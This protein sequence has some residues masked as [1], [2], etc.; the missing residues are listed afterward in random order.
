MRHKMPTM[1]KNMQR[2]LR[3]R[4]Q[5]HLFHFWW[6]ILNF[7]NTYMVQSRTFCNVGQN[8]I[9][10]TFAKDDLALKYALLF[11]LLYWH[12][13][14]WGLLACVWTSCL[15]W[16]LLF[17][18]EAIFNHKISLVTPPYQR[19]WQMHSGKNQFLL[20]LVLTSDHLNVS[21]IQVWYNA[22][23]GHTSWGP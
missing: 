19:A 16:R 9:W 4:F 15:L 17:K 18:N 22:P 1:L 20:S 10:C 23:W 13:A 12:F 6:E 7:T 5:C 2:K 3:E 21:N 11:A 8:N 14:V